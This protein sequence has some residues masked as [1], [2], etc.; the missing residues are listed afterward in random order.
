MPLH[1]LASIKRALAR[2][3]DE[4]DDFQKHDRSW[5]QIQRMVASHEI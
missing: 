1:T 3:E 2:V 4:L 5:F